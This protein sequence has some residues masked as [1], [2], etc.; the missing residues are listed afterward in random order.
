MA[1]Y[2]TVD[3]YKFDAQVNYGW[4]L[5]LNMTGKAPEVSKRIFDTY[6]HMLYYVN[7][8]NDSC[9][10][11]LC[12]KVMAD[13]DKNG[14]YFVSAIGTEGA[15]KAFANDGVVLKLGTDARIIA[16]EADIKAIEDA[17]GE[18]PE[19]K[20][21]AQMFIDEK[22]AR[23]NGIK[24]AIEA[25]DVAEM[26]EAGKFV[27]SVSQTDG[28]VSVEF[29][30]VEASEVLVNKTEGEGGNAFT[31]ETVQGVL[32]EIQKEYMAADDVLADAMDKAIAAEAKAREDA[33]KAITGQMAADK[34]ELEKAIE[35]AQA[36]AEAAATKMEKAADATHLTLTH[37]TDENTGAITYTIGESD[38]ASAQGLANEIARAESA[39]TR[40][41]N[42]ITAETAAREAA[43]K[44]ITGQMAADKAE[45]NAAITAE[46]AARE[47]AIKT[48]KERAE[49]AESGLSEA[50]TAEKERAEAAESGL[51]EAI[52]AEKERAEAA[53]S[54][55]TKAIEDEISARTEADDA[56][57][58]KIG[59]IAD[60]KTVADTIADV[61]AELEGKIDQTSADKSYSIVS[62]TGDELSALGTNVKEAYKLVDGTSAHTQAGDYIKIYKDS[63]L[64]DVKLE[65]QNL[66]FTYILANGSDS[67]ITVDVS[68]FL[69][70]NEYAEGLQVVDHKISV[71][72]DATS[73]D[74]L[75]VSANGVKVSGVQ[76]AIDNA[77]AAEAVLRENAD[78]A[79]KERAESAET[80]LNNAITALTKTVGDNKTDIENKLASA[81]TEL[82]EAIEAEKDRA[83]SAETRL[84]DAITAETSN[85]EAADK[86]INDK[87]GN[88]PADKTVV[89]M[90]E[91]AEAAAI[92]AA[93][94]VAEDSDFIEIEQTGEVGKTQTYTIKTVD[95]ASASATN[96][97][98]SAETEARKNAIS[99][100][101]ET[102]GNN[103]TDIEN[104]LSAETSARTEAITAV[105]ND[106]ASAETR[107]NNAI[108]SAVTEE[109][110]RA[111]SAETALSD[112]IAA[113]E[114][115]DT[116]V[117]KQIE[118]AVKVE[119]DRAVS[120]ETALSDRIAAEVSART[121]ADNALDGRLDTLEG[122]KI[123]GKDAI[124]VSAEGATDNK[125]V[126]LKLGA[127]PAENTAGVVLSQDT[128]GLVAKLQWGSF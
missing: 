51:S 94:I 76:T 40:L 93:T 89:G 63:A 84:N 121:E 49:A 17:L 47:A 73:E 46:T 20:T 21:I 114:S 41:N 56:I 55:L 78:K 23:E 42:A 96:A 19:G 91:A 28:K 79:E 48:E 128:N 66:V 112:R 5:T 39:E 110:D 70:E 117:A 80:A 101:T 27:S 64:K 68:A 4:G 106:L 14:V 69:S 34:A 67:A 120:A 90:I 43:D 95:V 52:T 124:V 116:S 113:F 71:K 58:D 11:G 62:V 36:A 123:T 88:V 15:D 38:I 12:L 44:T 50:I 7:D 25:L 22:T 59:D 99:A 111:V 108:T 92:A 9:V 30:A 54:G 53:E 125:E 35:D 118:N 74:F 87:I 1:N 10:P 8:Y 86:A 83:E 115:G 65:G 81:K 37:V 97:A 119:H 127:Q 13:G 102:V 2:T 104:K 3:G 31:A 98:I 57:Y 103:K 109:H 85:R 32:E 100:L 33:D 24:A 16:A 126:S 77:V 29:K 26:A 18:L 122:V 45:L 105:R 107:L 61:K 82:E 6:A 72:R 60:D 75:S